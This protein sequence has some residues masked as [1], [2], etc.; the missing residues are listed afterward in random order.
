M[1]KHLNGPDWESVS[2]YALALE[3]HSEGT[4]SV[5]LSP[6]LQNGRESFR[7]EVYLQLPRPSA[8]A[9]APLIRADGMWPVRD[10]ARLEALVYHLLH[11]IDQ[12]LAR[13]WVQYEM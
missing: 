13:H 3:S 2:A 4:V 9:S 10:F 1:G 7:V 6:V 8:S 5:E 12:E 11:R